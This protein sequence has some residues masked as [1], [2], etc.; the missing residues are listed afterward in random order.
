MR[1]PA[2][3]DLRV[4]TA[5]FCTSACEAVDS[6]RR[7]PG[8]SGRLSGMQVA[9]AIQRLGGVGSR[10]RLI[11]LT[12]RRAVDRALRRGTIVR[13]GH[14]RYALPSAAVALRVASRLSA[15]V[16]LRSAAMHWGWEQKW[17]P[18]IP[19]VTFPRNRKVPR[20]TQVQVNAH[21]ADLAP[22][23][24]AEDAPV[25]SRRRTLVDCLRR[26]PFD[27]ALAIADSALRH[28]DFTRA[29]L[30]E[31]AGA[32]TGPGA[33]QARHVARHADPRAANPFESVLRAISL[34]VEGLT[35]V[36]QVRLE[37]QRVFVTPD[38]L[39]ASLRLVAEAD[40]F[41]WHGNRRALRRDCHRYN[42]LVL[43]GWTVLRFTWEDVMLHPAYV[44]GCLVAAA[45]R[46]SQRAQ[47]PRR[48]RKAA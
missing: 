23:D 21:W 15:V 7:R 24:V 13:D 47:P 25:T 40:S 16:S 9:E 17:A 4:L 32:V 8:L 48:S 43:R 2:A 5:H 28:G 11:E 31:L 3:V 35:L 6:G 41:E 34:S 29:E 26:L 14:G 12:S 44:H 10:K 22:G 33:A 27:E 45:R 19:D 20:D 36:P 18:D 1:N 30:A 39:D 46:G 37:M 38:L 42:L